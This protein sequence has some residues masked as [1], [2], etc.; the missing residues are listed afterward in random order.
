MTQDLKKLNKRLIKIEK[1]LEKVRG[2][3]SLDDGW[4]TQRLAKKQRKWDMLAQE[5]FK[6]KQRI[7]EIEQDQYNEGMANAYYCIACGALLE[8]ECICN[9]DI[10]L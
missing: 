3:N 5:K 6:I 2:C 4:Q 1:E 8:E 7:E 10:E 9:Y